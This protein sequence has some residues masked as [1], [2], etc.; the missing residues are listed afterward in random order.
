MPPTIDISNDFD[1]FYGVESVTYSRRK[2]DASIA[3]TYP[4]VKAV[5]RTPGTAMAGVGGG[6]AKA[7]VTE[8][9]WHLKA[10]D[11][12]LGVR[13]GDQFTRANGEVWEVV[14][15]QLVAL[16]TRYVCNC[17]KVS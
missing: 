12:P 10:L 17:K 7:I 8:A 1:L 14:D 9:R 2:L 5:N 11:L 15:Y 6:N 16:S 4:A 13:V 3:A